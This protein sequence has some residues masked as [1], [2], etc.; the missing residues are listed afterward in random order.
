MENN[1]EMDNDKIVLGAFSVLACMGGCLAG[2]LSQRSKIN[3]MTVQYNAELER[4]NQNRSMIDKLVHGK[5]AP[6]F[7]IKNKK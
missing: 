2:I 3:K 5:N 7:V 6:R 1:F 4:L